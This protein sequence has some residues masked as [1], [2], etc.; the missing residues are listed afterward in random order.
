MKPSVRGELEIT[1]LNEMYLHENSDVINKS[2]KWCGYKCHASQYLL[3][4]DREAFLGILYPWLISCRYSYDLIQFKGIKMKMDSLKG[5]RCYS[6][7]SKVYYILNPND[8][9][10]IF[11]SKTQKFLKCYGINALVEKVP[12]FMNGSSELLSGLLRN[13][14]Y[15]LESVIWATVFSN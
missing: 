8:N 3:E 11:D 5:K 10:L 14:F 7:A 12:K 4:K 2:I 13:D 1:T 15:L 9:Q 6:W